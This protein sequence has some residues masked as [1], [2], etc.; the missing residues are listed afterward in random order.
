[1]SEVRIVTLVLSFKDLILVADI[2]YQSYLPKW[3]SISADVGWI[4]TS[5]L[6]CHMC[7][8]KSQALLF[9]NAHEGWLDSGTAEESEHLES[10][11]TMLQPSL[12]RQSWNSSPTSSQP[13]RT[14]QEV[15]RARETKREL[16]PI[17]SKNWRT[18]ELIK[19]S[20]SKW[21]ETLNSS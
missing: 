9:Q 14:Q 17:L 8:A 4:S 15:S 11:C 19:K 5:G 16:T 10:V 7:P 1:M 20:V 6:P 3:H 18:L 21:K 2:V 13:G 12:L